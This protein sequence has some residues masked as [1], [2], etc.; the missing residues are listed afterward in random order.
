MLTQCLTIQGHHGSRLKG[1][2]LG[3]ADDCPVVVGAQEPD[4][5]A[6]SDSLG[7]K[8]VVNE[9]LLTGVGNRS[10]AGHSRAELSIQVDAEGE[11]VISQCLAILV[12]DVRSLGHGGHARKG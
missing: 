9:N 6:K 7:L 10:A 12:L 3:E 8:G 2:V 4:C 11:D 5:V 1:R